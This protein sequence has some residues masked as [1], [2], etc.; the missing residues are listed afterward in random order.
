M[1]F[2]FLSEDKKIQLPKRCNFI[3]I[4][5]DEV[6]KATF[7]DNN[8][9]VWLSPRTI[10]G[11]KVQLLIVLHHKCTNIFLLFS[12]RYSVVGAFPHHRTAST[13]IH[14]YSKSTAWDIHGYDKSTA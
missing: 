14:G 5:I 12:R 10:L 4:L 7:K 9:T 3:E 1:Y 2:P 11:L 13:D 8:P 6:Q